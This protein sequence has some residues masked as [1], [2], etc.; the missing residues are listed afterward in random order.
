[1]AEVSRLSGVVEAIGTVAGA[2]GVGGT[3][4]SG[5]TATA[6]PPTTNIKHEVRRLEQLRGAPIRRLQ[7]FLDNNTP[8]FLYN[9]TIGVE[10]L[11]ILGEI[12]GLPLSADIIR[13][14][15]DI[16][17]GLKGYT[18]GYNWGPDL[19]LLWQSFLGRLENAELLPRGS[20]FRHFPTFVKK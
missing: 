13:L 12:R 7:A 15:R 9:Q 3:T 2:G 4:D 16:H 17:C 8:T 19:H 10:L 6:P 1:M 20:L 18:F 11:G 14:E 5:R